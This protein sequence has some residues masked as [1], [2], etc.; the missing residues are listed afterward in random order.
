ML[1]LEIKVQMQPLPVSMQ[2]CRSM[3]YATP[4]SMI[5][6]EGVLNN[7]I[8]AIKFTLLLSLVPLMP[9]LQSPWLQQSHGIHG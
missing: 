9:S 2:T 6:R 4:T 5:V 7:G 8:T 3:H 1:L